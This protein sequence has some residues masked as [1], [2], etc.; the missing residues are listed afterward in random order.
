MKLLRIALPLLLLALLGVAWAEEGQEEAPPPARE[1]APP[2]GDAGG[3]DPFSP[4]EGLREAGEQEEGRTFV[5]DDSPDRLPQLALRGYIEDGLGKAVA[6][7][8]VEGRTTYLV[9]KDDTVSLPM[10]GRNTVIRVVEV[11][12][13]EL[14]VEVGELRREVVVR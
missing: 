10:R 2:P 3:A 6:L 9:S 1:E 14:R 11:G 7:L 8:E 13:L 4:G 5:P 12:N